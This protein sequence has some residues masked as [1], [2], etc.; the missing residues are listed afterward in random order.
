[1][2]SENCLPPITIKGVTITQN[3][4]EALDALQGHDAD[5]MHFFTE[6]CLIISSLDI[7]RFGIERNLFLILRDMYGVMQ[8]LIEKGGKDASN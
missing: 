4:I 7:D 1:M 3:L 8:A 6:Q 5:D 2:A